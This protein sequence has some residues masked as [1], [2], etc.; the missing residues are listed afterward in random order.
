MVR[1]QSSVR[2]DQISAAA[3][4]RAGVVPGAAGRSAGRSATT[5]CTDARGPWHS[6]MTRITGDAAPA[7]K[8]TGGGAGPAPGAA[9]TV[10]EPAVGPD[11][12][13]LFSSQPAPTPAVPVSPPSAPTAESVFGDNPWISQP[14]GTGPGGISY[15]YNPVYF[16][17][18]QTAAKV[19]DMVG[20]TVVESNQFTPNGGPFNQSQPN[21][22]VRLNDGSMI[23][24]GLVASFYTHGY[25]QSYVDSM[26]AAEIRNT[27][28]AS[29]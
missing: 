12:R 16:A 3:A 13:A 18:Q 23:N 1:I 15:G 28:G 6:Q 25:P 5:G 10:T 17:T 27:T 22:M 14:V 21:Y 4:G 19:A 11:W 9:K 8:A 7:S 26:I 24:P 2:T 29:V 20:G